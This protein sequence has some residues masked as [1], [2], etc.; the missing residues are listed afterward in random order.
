MRVNFQVKSLCP[1]IPAFTLSEVMLVLSVIGVIA[2]LTIPGLIQS[3]NDRQSKVVLKKTFSSLNQAALSIINEYGSFK[4]IL[5]TNENDKLSNLFQTQFNV[6][7]T[8]NMGSL[9]NGCWKAADDCT[10]M[11]DCV[12][13]DN[14]GF[15]TNAGAFVTFDYNY[16][17]CTGEVESKVCGS[18]TVDVNG[19]SAPNKTGKD[20]FG[21]YITENSVKPK[22]Y[23]GEVACDSTGGIGCSAQYLMGN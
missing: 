15:V 20:I 11:A 18:I 6:I 21:F 13:A 5:S 4:N 14:S 23:K 9:N 3:L 16:P 17:D 22:G 12:V 2:A 19:A 8:C 10:A 7:K 1:N